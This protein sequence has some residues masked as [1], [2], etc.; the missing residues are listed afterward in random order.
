ME[1]KLAGS[2]LV[3][4]ELWKILGPKLMKIGEILVS[5][6]KRTTKRI[7]TNPCIF[8]VLLKKNKTK[9]NKKPN[10][11]NITHRQG[12]SSDTCYSLQ[13]KGHEFIEQKDKWS[14]MKMFEKLCISYQDW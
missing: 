6:S 3:T 12:H 2:K 4:K 7:S 11:F 14:Q 8:K 10:S 5:K 1:K 13:V 9:Q